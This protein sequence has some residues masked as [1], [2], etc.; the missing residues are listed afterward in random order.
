MHYQGSMEMAKPTSRIELQEYCLRKL[1]QPVINVNV[2]QE[3][4]DDRIDEA[5]ETYTEKHYDATEELWMY[6]NLTQT[7]VDNGYVTVD[8][9]ILSV[10]EILPAGLIRGAR[11]S[12]DM[13]SYQYQIMVNQLSPWDPFDSLDYFMKMT[14]LESTRQMI[15]V[16]PRFKY[17]RHERKV[18]I[19]DGERSVGYPIVMRAF[20]MIDP[21][22]V[23]NDKWLKEYATALIKRQWGENVSKFEGIELLGG[24]KINGD[25]LMRE[26]AEEIEKLEIELQDTY[27]EPTDF[28]F[29]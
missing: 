29:G 10:V 17:V 9:N 15:D 6:H 3:Q 2:A 19:Y 7:D 20:R 13:F 24:V 27:M 18:K 12:S 26:S 11:D 14:D 16:D 4:I 23:W 25:R 5:I 28:L 8:D 21:E 1:G 22:A